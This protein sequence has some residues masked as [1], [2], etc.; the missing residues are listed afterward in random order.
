[1]TPCLLMTQ[2][3]HPVQLRRLGGTL[4]TAKPPG[5]SETSKHHALGRRHLPR[6]PRCNTRSLPKLRYCL[7]LRSRH[8]K[9]RSCN[10]QGQRPRRSKRGLV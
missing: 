3:R 4:L 1:M 5:V 9:A 8:P 10:R 7:W 2:S 6:C